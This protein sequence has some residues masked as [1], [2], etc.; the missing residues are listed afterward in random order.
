MGL[1]SYL[2][3]RRI[4]TRE[5][6]EIFSGVIFVYL[7]SLFLFKFNQPNIIC[8]LQLIVL[9]G[10]ANLYVI[11]FNNF[12]MPVLAGPRT[13]GLARQRSP[14]R[15]FCMLTSRT[16]LPWFADRFFM[17]SNIYSIGDAMVLFGVLVILL[18]FVVRGI[19]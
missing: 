17:G 15:G 19:T 3:R 6:L 4:A 16:K 1:V 5:M 7:L 10:M 14:K 12:K 9:G 18:L 11:D 13:V 8:G 2:E